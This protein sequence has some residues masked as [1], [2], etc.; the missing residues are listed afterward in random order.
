M[1]HT[2]VTFRPIGTVLTK[3]SDDQMKEESK[4]LD[5]TIE[6]LPEFLDG[7]D[8]LDGCSHIFVLTYLNKLRP[9]QIGPLKVKPRRL[10]KKGFK[11]EDLP[12]VGVFAIDSPTRPNPIGLTLV[13]LLHREGRRLT[14]RGLDCFNGTPVLDIKPYKESYALSDYTFPE[15]HSRLREITGED[16]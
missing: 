6:I 13:E 15:W 10:L 5:S 12:L 16:I 3:A 1:N 14:V 4:E 7:L 8:G 9:D 2:K 11:L